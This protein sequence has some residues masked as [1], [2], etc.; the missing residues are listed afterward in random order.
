MF[1]VK[2]RRP[3]VSRET[4][5][6]AIIWGKEHMNMLWIGDV[7]SNMGGMDLI[8]AALLIISILLLLLSWRMKRRLRHALR[9]SNGESLDQK[10]FELQQRL[11]ELANDQREIRR[12]MKNMEESQSQAFQKAG[13]VRFNA[14]GDTG[15]DLSFSLAL[16]N[17]HGDG[18]VLTNIY[19]REESRMYAKP[20]HRFQSSYVLTQEEQEALRQAFEPDAQIQIAAANEKRTRKRKHGME[21]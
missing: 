1:H 3:D 13:L 5:W 8:G 2:H 11:Q 14:F 21:H 16:L 9:L 15:G 19:S 18:V 12:Q 10:L 20:V 4:K 17:Q 7:W 6:M